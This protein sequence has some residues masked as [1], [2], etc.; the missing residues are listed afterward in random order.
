M[1]EKVNLTNQLLQRLGKK[2]FTYIPLLLEKT[3]ALHVFKRLMVEAVV[4]AIARRLHRI[5]GN[6]REEQNDARAYSFFHKREMYCYMGGFYT[7]LW[8]CNV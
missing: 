2:V 4:S 7:A 6:I 3:V 5:V 1:M 8:V